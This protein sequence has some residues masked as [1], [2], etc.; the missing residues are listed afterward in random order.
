MYLYYLRKLIRY[1]HPRLS[2]RISPKN[3]YVGFGPRF[4]LVIFFGLIGSG[5]NHY[6]ICKNFYNKDIQDRILNNN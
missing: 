3:A 2:Y 4:N 6:R 1:Q 5:L